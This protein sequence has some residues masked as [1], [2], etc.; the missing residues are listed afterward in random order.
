MLSSGLVRVVQALMRRVCWSFWQATNPFP[1]KS[2]KL[3][4][5]VS[6]TVRCPFSF[7]GSENTGMQCTL[8]PVQSSPGDEYM[9][10]IELLKA[11]RDKAAHLLNALDTSIRALSG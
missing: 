7:F 8:Y 5:R 9:D 11:E 1:G 6:S 2:L 3:R 10:I 4:R